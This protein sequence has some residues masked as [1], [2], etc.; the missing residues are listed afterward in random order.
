MGGNTVASRRVRWGLYAEQVECLY[1]RLEALLA[2]VDSAAPQ[3]GVRIVIHGDHGSRIVR[4]MP[5][6]E[7]ATELTEEDLLDGFATL[8]AVR[9]PGI[10]PGVDSAAVAVQ[11]GV[12]LL[13]AGDSLETGRATGETTPAV[14]LE[15]YGLKQS[16]SP[17]LLRFSAPSLAR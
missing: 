7:N 10:R 1:L 16:G 17:G 5:F 6:P 12:P 11:D 3:Q 14:M 13:V 4:T 15:T 8:L 2:A 9:G